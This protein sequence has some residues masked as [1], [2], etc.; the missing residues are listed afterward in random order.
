MLAL[1]V[2]GTAVHVV[3]SLVYSPAA[4]HSTTR[5]VAYLAHL[6]PVWVLAFGVTAVLLGADLWWSRGLWLA[7]LLCAAVW[8]AYDAGLWVGVFANHPHGTVFFPIVAVAPIA[9]HVI[10][11]ASYNEDAAYSEGRRP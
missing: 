10:L 4:A 8:V 2:I 11:A 7:H 9:V 1:Q 3:P 5:I 6:G